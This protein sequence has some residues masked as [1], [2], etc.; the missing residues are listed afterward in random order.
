MRY[1]TIAARCARP[2]FFRVVRLA[3]ETLQ[4][5]PIVA[6]SARLCKYA[7]RCLGRDVIHGGADGVGVA[8]RTEDIPASV[9]CRYC[10]VKKTM[11]TGIQRQLIP[12]LPGSWIRSWPRFLIPFYSVFALPVGQGAIETTPPKTEPV[13]FRSQRG[14][15]AQNGCCLFR[16]L[17]VLQFC[18]SSEWIQETAPVGLF[19]C[20]PRSGVNKC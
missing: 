1:S 12:D 15:H 20:R 5:S 13:E 2:C 8:C 17:S 18:K 16:A 4:E 19:F 9:P 7:V 6:Q 11:L 3:V 10:L 14:N